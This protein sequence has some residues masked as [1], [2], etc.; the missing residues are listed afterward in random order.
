MSETHRILRLK[1]SPHADR[2]PS[3]LHPRLRAIGEV[4]WQKADGKLA[5][6]RDARGLARAR[7]GLKTAFRELFGPLPDSS[8][9]VGFRFGKT[10]VYQDVALRQVVLRSA[11]GYGISA[12]VYQ[13]RDLRGALPGLVFASGHEEMGSGHPP[14]VQF[15]V[16][17]AMCGFLVVAFDPPGQGPR[18]EVFLRGDDPLHWRTTAQHQHLGAVT[19]LLGHPLSH[20][21]VHDAMTAVSFLCQRPEV[22]ASRIGFAGHSGG[23]LQTYWA[24][25]ADSRIRVAVPIKS[26]ATRRS[27]FMNG[28]LCDVEQCPHG[29]WSRGFD[30]HEMAVLFAPRPLQIVMEPG[31]A[32][33]GDVYRKLEPIYRRLGFPGN[34]ALH[35][36]T[37]DH[38][39]GRADREAAMQWLGRHLAPAD[40]VPAEP[41]WK[42]WEPFCRELQG[43]RSGIRLRNDGILGYCQKEARA[44]RPSLS[45]TARAIKGIPILKDAFKNRGVLRDPRGVLLRKPT[46]GKQFLEL[47]HGDRVPVVV[48]RGRCRNGVV[49]LVVD[50]EGT[51]SPRAGPSRLAASSLSEWVVALEVFPGD[52]RRDESADPGSQR[53]P[54]FSEGVQRAMEAGMAGHCP[55]GLALGE[56]R[57]LLEGPAWSGRPLLLFGRGWPA[58]SLLLLSAAI[59][60]VVG[61]CLSGMP[62]SYEMLREAGRFCVDYSHLIPGILKA[63]DLPILLRAHPKTRYV[64]A[65][66]LEF[67]RDPARRGGVRVDRNVLH[68]PRE[69]GVAFRG[70]ITWLGRSVPASRTGSAS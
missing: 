62:R 63:T 17:A 42:G 58:V 34:L 4:A 59:P 12:L 64:L 54:W 43:D 25:A 26:G 39:L 23:G 36:S 16:F 67:G 60:R 3:A 29:A 51:D 61:C 21:F 41:S 46:L 55:I 13:R 48:D 15:C 1:S 70:A 2:K 6:I 66:P 11:L 69:D 49:A 45:G 10:R 40:E 53:E 44:A 37:P 47:A 32:P 57:A 28:E 35:S 50:E 68:L 14:Y 56:I 7:V 19:T 33:Q 22:D 27:A 65:S 20:F 9:R 8:A 52:D 24:M 18:R 30:L 31:H 38:G 5:A